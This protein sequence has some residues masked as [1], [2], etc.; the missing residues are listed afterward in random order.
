MP[1][2][3][4]ELFNARLIVG[5]DEAGADPFDVPA[6]LDRAGSHVSAPSVGNRRG[7]DPLAGVLGDRAPLVDNRHPEVIG[8]HGLATLRSLGVERRLP[9]GLD[10]AAGQGH[11]EADNQPRRLERRPLVKLGMVR[12]QDWEG[13]ARP[14]IAGG[15]I[16]YP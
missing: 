4:I 16:E 10:V 15:W 9:L 1:A 3:A 14:A 12:V 6:P 5:V 7:P 8:D 2:E 11:H 13:Y